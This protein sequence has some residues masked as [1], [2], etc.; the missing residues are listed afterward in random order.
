[1]QKYGTKKDVNKY[2]KLWQKYYELLTLFKSITRNND[3]VFE[4]FKNKISS[5]RR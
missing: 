2:D 3:V 5:V 1:M 4:R